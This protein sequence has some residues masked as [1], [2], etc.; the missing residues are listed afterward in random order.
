V[1]NIE[2]ERSKSLPWSKIQEYI[3]NSVVTKTI[4]RKINGNVNVMSCD[5]WQ[6]LTE[7]TSPFDTFIQVIDGKAEI[8]IDD[9]SSHLEAGQAVIIPE[10]SRN[11]IKANIRFKMLSTI[12]KSSYEDLS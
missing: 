9:H 10:H 5:T 4:L 8:M 12:I 6:G 11:T 3:P 7:R 1:D 2:V